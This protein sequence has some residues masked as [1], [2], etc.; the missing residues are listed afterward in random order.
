M[1]DLSVSGP[2]RKAQITD[3]AVGIT[4]PLGL[5]TAE[6]GALEQQAM[7]RMAGDCAFAGAETAEVYFT[8]AALTCL[9]V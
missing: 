7:I 5:S 8:C 2:A 1:V 9:S 3:L 4:A 6:T